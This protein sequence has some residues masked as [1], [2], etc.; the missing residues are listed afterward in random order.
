MKKIFTLMLALACAMF[1]GVSCTPDNGGEQGGGESYTS[2]V[3]VTGAPE[4]NLAPEAGELTLGYTITNPSL[5]AALSITT[6]A[7]WVHVGEVGETSVA[8]TYDANTESPGSP[9]REAVVVFAYE[10]AK[11][12]NV[13]LKQD[14]QTPSFSVEFLNVTPQT[15]QY[16]CTPVDNEMLYLLVSSQD[17]GQYGVQGA[18]PAEMMQNYIQLLA[19][20]DMLATQPDYWFVYQ[21]ANTE[22]PKEASRW[23]AEDSVTVYAVGFKATNTKEADGVVFATEAEL[24]TAVHVWNVPFLPYP[25]LTIAEA[26]LNKTVS[27]A[28][29]EVTIDC[30][31]E[32][33]VEGT[34]LMVE[35]E[36]A[37][38]TASYADGKITLAYEANTAAVAR[39]ASIAVSYGYFTNPTEIILVQEKDANAQAITLNIEV[40]GTQFNGII[41]NVTPSDAEAVYALN[42][43]AVEKDYE[44]GAELEMDWLGKAEE[45]LSYTGTATFHQGTLTNHFIKMNP[46]YYQWNGYDYYVYGVPVAATSEGDRWTVSQI[47]GEVSYTKTTIDAS[48]MPKLEWDLTKTEGLVWNENNERYDIEAVE[49]ST[50][51]LHFNVIN[52]AEGA[53]VTLNGTSL[54]DSYNVVDGEPVIDNEAGTI[55]IKVDKFDTSKKYHYVSLTFKYT[56]AEGDTWGITTPGLRLT[57]VQQAE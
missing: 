6:E 48:K 17:L 40:V 27:S 22:M 35:T 21:G 42:Q 47:L 14:S 36:A 31:I 2:T 1:V 19:S 24:A 29:G 57:Q 38:V 15:A 46:S 55:T 23:S 4:A 10:G 44:T 5:T 8:L 16:V 51:V 32:N 34:E 53:F 37:W 11:S 52:P 39:R 49:G 54:Y 45:L 20:N 12:V 28:A 9:A 18:T 41:V 56:N 25:S 30:A 50:I 3:A 7:T 26:D 43:C 33:P 13:T